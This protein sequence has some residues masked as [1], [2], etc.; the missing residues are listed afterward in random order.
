M[1]KKIAFAN[2]KGGVGKTSNSCMV[3]YE[4]SK[5]GKRVLLVDLDPQANATSLLLMTAQNIKEHVIAFDTTLMAAISQGDLRPIVTEIKENLDLLPSF[6]DFTSYGLYLEKKYPNSQKDRVYHFSNL[7]KELE[8]DYDY[9]IMDTPPTLSIYT[10]SAVACS[11][12]VVIVMQTQKRSLVGA[13]G[14]VGYLQ[15]MVDTYGMDLSILG[16]LP[17]LM[18]NDSPLDNATLRRAVA[19]FGEENLFQNVVSHSERVKRYDETGITDN[20]FK[21]D[22]RITDPHD[23]RTHEFYTEVAKEFLERMNA[24]G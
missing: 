3:A 19:T 14:F 17:V 12:E 9:I 6:A 18:K 15:E 7:L 2:F 5:M 13:E 21:N 22:N 11:D 16:I 20:D 8:G 24:N 10:D 4:L 1:V 23:K